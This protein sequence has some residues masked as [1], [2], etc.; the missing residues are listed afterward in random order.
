MTF[1]R[2]FVS[3]KREAYDDAVMRERLPEPRL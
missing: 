3:F 2:E 1:L